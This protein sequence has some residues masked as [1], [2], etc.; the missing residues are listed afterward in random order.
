MLFRSLADS[1]K[2]IALERLSI[3]NKIADAILSGKAREVYPDQGEDDSLHFASE[4][5]KNLDDESKNK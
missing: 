3:F 2:G 5:K 1:Q 4:I